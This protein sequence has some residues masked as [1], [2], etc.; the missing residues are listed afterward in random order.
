[1]VNFEAVSFFVSRD[2][3]GSLLVIF[4]EPGVSEISSPVGV[5]GM[6]IPRNDTPKRS[7]SKIDAPSCTG[8]Y[9]IAVRIARRE[10]NIPV[11]THAQC[12]EKLRV[13][14]DT[15]RKEVSEI[16]HGSRQQVYVLPH[17]TGSC[18]ARL[19]GSSIRTHPR[20][21]AEYFS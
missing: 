5:E 18:T 11:A 6:H 3:I 10:K 7:D 20:I 17:D 21:A 12:V 19:G 9:H 2:S 13:A 14:R 4:E 15:R 1:M 16:N 8:I